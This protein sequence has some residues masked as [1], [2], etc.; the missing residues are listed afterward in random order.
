MNY[1][2]LNLNETFYTNM[3]QSWAKLNYN[4]PI[5]IQEVIRQPLWRNSLIKINGKTIKFEDWNKAGIKNISHLIDNKGNLASQNFLRYKYGI[6]HS[7]SVGWKK[8][9]KSGNCTLDYT[10]QQG[11]YIY[12]DNKHC[13][14]NNNKGYIYICNQKVENKTCCRQNKM[15]CV[16][17]GMCVIVTLYSS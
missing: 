1:E 6:I 3:F 7:I 11:C 5:N 12:I 2:E 15:F 17:G 16:V 9:I 10:P 8:M 13:N 14:R 4:E